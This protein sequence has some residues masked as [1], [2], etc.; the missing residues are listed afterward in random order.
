MLPIVEALER[1][2]C[3]ELEKIVVDGDSDKFFQVGAQLPPRKKEELVVFL[4]G[5]IDV[6]T[7][8][9]YEAPGVDSSF[10]C[11]HLNVNPSIIPRNQPHRR[12]SKE[13]FDAVRD[14]LIK[15][16]QAGAI[17]KIFLPRVASQYCSGEEEER[18][19][20]GLC[21]LHIFEQG[22]SKEPFPHASN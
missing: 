2:K 3:E 14:E 6:F 15:L 13:H 5:N 19:V 7:W 22:L 1:A 4:K 16:K 8:N 11:H 20:A 21:G 10:I 12:L 9:V 17:K 18:T